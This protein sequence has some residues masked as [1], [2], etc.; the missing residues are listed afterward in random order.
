MDEQSRRGLSQQKDG[1]ESPENKQK[2]A[3]TGDLMKWR[4]PKN[5][6]PRAGGVLLKDF[7]NAAHPLYRL[8]GVVNWAQCERQFGK[9]YAEE[10]GRPALATRLVV[11]L[12]YLKYLYNVS[13]EVVGASWVEN[14]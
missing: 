7:L 5:G 14:P 2:G 6:A 1:L 11:G 4:K 3:R 13:D 8:A 12:H 9:F 10:M